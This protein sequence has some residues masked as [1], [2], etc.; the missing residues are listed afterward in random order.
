MYQLSRRPVRTR[1]H[2]VTSRP[3][4]RPANRPLSSHLTHLPTLSPS[5]PSLTN[6]ASANHFISTGIKH[7]DFFHP[8][9]R[10]L[11]IGLLGDKMTGKTTLALDALIF[12]I[13]Q[14]RLQP[15]ANEQVYGVYVCVGKKANEMRRVRERRRAT[16]CW[17][18][19]WVVC[20][21]DSDSMG[22]PVFSAVQR[23]YGGGWLRDEGKH[24][25][26]VY[27]DTGDARCDL[28]VHR[29]VSKQSNR[30][31]YRRDR[32]RSKFVL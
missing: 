19:A 16:A 15:Q 21:S 13:Q 29:Q 26:I 1:P 4:L 30:H 2:A 24:V 7:L 25:V 3:A 20:S 8:L 6:R 17:T 5:S 22:S 14:S 27:D 18:A 12:I 23:L 32:V 31:S 11:R 9:T 10:G 28:H